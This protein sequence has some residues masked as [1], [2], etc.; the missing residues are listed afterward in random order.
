M[1]KQQ[2]ERVDRMTEPLVVGRH[3][4]VWT[5]HARWHKR[6]KD[7][8]VIGP[9]HNDKDFFNFGMQHYH[10]DSRFLPLRMKDRGL[11]LSH[12]LHAHEAKYSDEEIPLGE[13]VLRRRKCISAES[14][15][16]IP[17]HARLDPLTKMREHFAGHQCAK[18]KGGWICPHRKASLGSV[19]PVDGIITC[20]LHLLK[21][22]AATGIVVP[23]RK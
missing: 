13:P 14:Q 18:G 1:K 23:V 5:V 21:I 17:W 9:R 22:D 3:Y 15:V 7:W 16:D 6:D 20:P 2:L 19:Q 4:L 11:S 10:L 12:P 8:P